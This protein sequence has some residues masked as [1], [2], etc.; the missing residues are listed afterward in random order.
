MCILV[1]LFIDLSLQNQTL[2]LNSC[3]FF[4]I[5]P[6]ICI[7]AVLKFIHSFKSS[8]DIFRQGFSFDAWFS[9]WS[10]SS[11]W[12]WWFSSS[13]STVAR[14]RCVG[15]VAYFAEAAVGAD[16]CGIG[17]ADRPG[18]SPCSYAFFWMISKYRSLKSRSFSRCGPHTH[19]HTQAHAHAQH[20]YKQHLTE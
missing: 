2:A 7:S 14:D 19:T 8:H 9:P 11:W 4:S 20:P 1:N 13:P 17:G 6:S 15:S 3:Q 10:G 18:P 12:F 16:D 5:S